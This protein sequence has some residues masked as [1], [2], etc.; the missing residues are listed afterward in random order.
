MVGGRVGSIIPV[1]ISTVLHKWAVAP[2]C[3]GP[4]PRKRI[5]SLEGQP[6]ESPLSDGHLHGIVVGKTSRFIFKNTR[7]PRKLVVIRL[8]KL[9]ASR[10]AAWRGAWQS[11]AR[12]G[13]RLV[14][15]NHSGQIVG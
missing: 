12:P 9:V 11:F 7:K 13:R 1:H 15:I 5:D 14:D 10:Y 8:P 2:F 4:V 6:V 3:G